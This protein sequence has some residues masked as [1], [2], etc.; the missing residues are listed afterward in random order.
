MDQ[1]EIY[2]NINIDTYKNAYLI[3][4][5]GNVKSIA[6]NRIMKP[7]PRNGYPSVGLSYQGKS[8]NY[9]IHRLVAITFLPNPNDYDCVNHKDGD[10]FNPVVENL[11]W[12]LHRITLNIHNKSWVIKH[13]L[14]KLDN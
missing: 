1:Q 7:Y 14:K 8:K 6:Y 12:L 4:N 13:L 3:S 11:E 5:M 2:L 10:R 9:M